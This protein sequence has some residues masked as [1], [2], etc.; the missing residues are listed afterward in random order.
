MTRYGAW[1][2]GELNMSPFQLAEPIILSHDAPEN[3]LE[4]LLSF[5]VCPEGKM[6]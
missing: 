4:S 2:A 1:Q 3:Q 6:D 5:L